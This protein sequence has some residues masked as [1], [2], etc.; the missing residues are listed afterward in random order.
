MTKRTRREHIKLTNEE[1]ALVIRKDGRLEIVGKKHINVLSRLASVM[2]SDDR[3]LLD[4]INAN[5]DALM[6]KFH[7]TKPPVDMK[8]DGAGGG[9]SEAVTTETE[10]EQESV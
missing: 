4:M 9:G 8:G 1:T 2:Y 5:H 3:V 6:E 7:P 10:T